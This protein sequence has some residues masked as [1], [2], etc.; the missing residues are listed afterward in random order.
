M[1][2]SQSIVLEENYKMGKI[3]GIYKGDFIDH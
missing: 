2:A 1:R 3:F